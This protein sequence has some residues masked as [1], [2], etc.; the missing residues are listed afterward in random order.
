VNLRKYPESY[1]Y[2]AMF[3]YLILVWIIHLGIVSVVNFFHFQLEHNLAIIEKWMSSNAWQVILLSKFLALLTCIK[4]FS[5]H[6]DDRRPFRKLIKKGLKAPNHVFFAIILLVYSIVFYFSFDGASQETIDKS[7]FSVLSY[8]AQF[9]FYSIDLVFIY[10]L[11]N[12]IK[13]KGVSLSEARLVLA[14]IFL[15]G[16][17]ILFSNKTYLYVEHFYPVFIFNFIIA[18][19]LM[20]YQK[21]NWTLPL[22]YLLS[23][24]V[25]LV[26]FLQLDP[27]ALEAGNLQP[28]NPSLVVLVVLVALI[29]LYLYF[30]RRKKLIS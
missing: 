11:T 20:I 9:S 13:I 1:L 29:N 23:C 22:L 10:L 8:L 6:L 17:I 21:L 27:V 28:L 30:H 26:I 24:G 18:L 5:I 12:H 25:P 7:V 16:I 2:V 19:R 14:Q 4:Y 15:S 3:V